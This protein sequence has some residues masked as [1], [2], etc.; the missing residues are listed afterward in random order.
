MELGLKDKVALVTGAGSQ[1]GIGKAIALMLA[2]EGCSVICNDINL[3]DAQ[4][5]AAEV[6]SLGR[7][8]LA[9]KADVSKNLEVAEMFRLIIDA[10]GR[11]DVLVNNAGGGKAKGPFCDQKEADWDIDIGLN[12][13]GAM[14]CTQA[15]L[16]QM[17][18][19]RQGKIINIASAVARAGAPNYEAYSACKAGVIGFTRSLAL[20]FATSGVN[21]NCVAPG[22]VA[23]NFGGGQPGADFLKVVEKVVPKKV[24]T[25]P[26]DIASMV[27]FLASDVSVNVLGQTVAVDGGYTMI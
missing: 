16:P 13:K 14:L 20:E 5:T 19:R 15:V 12:L 3:T 2:E 25:L 24:P 7:K 21:F 23:T 8:S 1:I 4:K 9:V 27:V 18:Q 22:F 11:I 10:F 17:L 26:R 6:A